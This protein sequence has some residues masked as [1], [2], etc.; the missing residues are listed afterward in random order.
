MSNHLSSYNTN[1]N[2]CISLLFFGFSFLLQLKSFSQINNYFG[3]SG[4]LHTAVWST[5]SLGPFNSFLNSTGGTVLNF[6]NP[7]T[8]TGATID[9]IGINV[10]ANV[11]WINNG[12]LGTNGTILP[13]NVLS[14]TTFI[15]SQTTSAAAGTGINK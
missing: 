4:T 12:T 6:N 8:I 13:I 5:S 11:N 9:V 7:A 14:G 10:S 2:I 1:N 15:M 3:N